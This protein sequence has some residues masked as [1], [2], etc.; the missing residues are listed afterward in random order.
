MPSKKGLTAGEREVIKAIV[1]IKGIKGS[2][3]GDSILEL[4]VIGA[5]SREV[6]RRV[7]PS[8]IKE[9]DTVQRNLILF[10][11]SKLDKAKSITPIE[12]LVS[13]KSRDLQYRLTTI[14]K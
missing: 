5:S 6:Q 12:L 13:K 4:D 11:L 10:G 7:S 2:M 14:M 9:E 1:S 3:L 8:L